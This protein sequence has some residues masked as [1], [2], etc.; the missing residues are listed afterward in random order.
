LPNFGYYKIG[1]K[2]KR[3]ESGLGASH[4]VG[5][6]FRQFVKNILS[7]DY[8]AANSMPFQIMD[9]KTMKIFAKIWRNCLE[10]ERARLR[11]FCVHVFNMVGHLS[12]ITKLGGK[13]KN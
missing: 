11:I 9:R 3:K 2:K 12:K 5:A 4:F 1:G 6:D 7:K 10:H 13:K 8:S